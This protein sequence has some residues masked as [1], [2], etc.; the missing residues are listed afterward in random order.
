[1]EIYRQDRERDYN[2]FLQID[3]KTEGRRHFILSSLSLY[4]VVDGLI[5]RILRNNK[6][7][8]TERA[9][10]RRYA[11]IQREM[12]DD[13][14]QHSSITEEI[15]TLTEDEFKQKESREIAVKMA[16]SAFDAFSSLHNY[17][18]FPKDFRLCLLCHIGCFLHHL[19][20]EAK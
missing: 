14:L 17:Y 6:I 20:G 13:I 19:A 16:F 5:D 9:E 11:A 10:I 7:P 8:V 15:P 18:R 3:S 4:T 1:M 2:T 12:A